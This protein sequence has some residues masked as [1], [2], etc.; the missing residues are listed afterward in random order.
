MSFYCFHIG[1]MRKTQSDLREGAVLW[2]VM[3]PCP[4]NFHSSTE[5]TLS[6]EKGWHEGAFLIAIFWLDITSPNLVTS[7]QW[8]IFAAEILLYLR[9][10]QTTNNCC[11]SLSFCFLLYYWAIVFFFHPDMADLLFIALRTFIRKYFHPLVR[12]F[13]TLKE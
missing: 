4:G 12:L 11:L 7:V 5:N 8:A 9:L 1:G 10:V 2:G 3:S 13:F 6:W